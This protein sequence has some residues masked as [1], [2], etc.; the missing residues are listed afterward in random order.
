MLSS[1][2]WQRIEVPDIRALPAPV[3]L[4]SQELAEREMFPVH[5]HDWHQFVYATAGTMVVT[6]GDCWYVISPEHAIWVPAGMPHTVGAM[7]GASFRNLY[8]AT[9]AAADLPGVGTQLQVTP[10]LR[11]LVL[12]FERLQDPHLQQAY[13]RQISQVL[14]AH[15][16]RLPRLDFHLPWPQTPM[17]LR[18]C[19]ALFQ[20]PADDR[21]LDDWGNQLGASARTL[22]RRFER[23]TGITFREWRYRLRLFLALEW[24]ANGQSVTAV[25]LELGYN[26]VSAFTH[27]FHQQTGCTPSH[28]RSRGGHPES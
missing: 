1:R 12:E 3:Y 13:S 18:L 28:W 11:E 22:S 4:R 21:S 14:L 27:M 16:Q 6:V 23:E 17:L 25:A 24:L 19:E 20:S 7:H 8:V 15:L 9:D 5:T 26:T 10:L 2:Q